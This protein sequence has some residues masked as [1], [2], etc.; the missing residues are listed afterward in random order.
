MTR[1]HRWF[2]LSI[3]FSLLLH[4]AALRLAQLN[5]APPVSRLIEVTLADNKPRPTAAPPASKPV[6]APVKNRVEKFI[7]PRTVVPQPQI[8]SHEFVLQ[9]TPIPTP[10]QRVLVAP[11]FAPLKLPTPLAPTPLPLP[12]PKGRPAP[13]P[14]TAPTIAPVAPTPIAPNTNNLPAATPQPTAPRIADSSIANPAP[15]NTPKRDETPRDNAKGDEKN[16]AAEGNAGGSSGSQSGGGSSGGQDAGGLNGNKGAG[17]TDKGEEKAGKPG[18][19]NAA[20]NGQGNSSG[21]G[22]GDDSGDG[23]GQGDGSAKGDGTGDKSG[24]GNGEGNGTDDKEGDGLGN[25][26]GNGRGDGKGDGSGKGGNGN[27]GNGGSGGGGNG[28]GGSLPFGLGK[29]GGSGPRH[30][31]YVLDVSWSMEP[32]IDRAENELRA[33]LKTL[34]P[35]ESFGIVALYKKTRVLEKQLLPATPANIAQANRFLNK[36]ILGDGTN[37]EG[38]MMRA[39][40]M[41]GVNVVVLITDGVPNYGEADFDNLAR[42]VRALNTQKARIFTVGLVGKNPDGSDDSFLATRLL[43][44]IALQNNGEFNRC[45]W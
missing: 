42:R 36:L 16:G 21:K 31:V 8:S 40:S 28:G 17:E 41:R 33:A 27:G 12:L 20:N 2:S 32:R 38:A 22:V 19:A 25:G 15:E 10:P 13:D 30:I 44:N 37:V 1:E 43:E 4:I 7:V 3:L 14:T 26:E 34:Q 29:G 23:Q 5:Q 6:R 18:A 45:H 11:T 9:P 35:N 39:L 24:L